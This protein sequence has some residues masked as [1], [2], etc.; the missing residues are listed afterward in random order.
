MARIAS[1][2]LAGGIVLNAIAVGLRWYST[3]HAPL[4]NLHESFVVVALSIAVV[5]LLVE[6]K[7]RIRFISAFSALM[8]VLSIGYASILD[9]SIQP[10]MPALKSN[11]LVIH[12]TAYFIGYGAL[13][14][15][16]VAAILYLISAAART[17]DETQLRRLDALSFRLILLSFPFLTVGLTTGAVWANVAWGRYWGWDPKE[18]WSLMTWLVYAVYLHLRT[19]RGWKN[20]RMAFVALIG[21]VFVIFTFFGVNFLLSGLHSYK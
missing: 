21:F 18:T 2:I 9:T 12:V 4:S 15:G 19:M 14:V 16:T 1:A 6:L 13:T 3:G 11:W 7:N 8:A 20:K 10:L 5:A 17:P